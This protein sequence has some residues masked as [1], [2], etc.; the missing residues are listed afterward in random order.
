MCLTAT[1]SKLTRFK[2]KE[3]MQLRQP[4]VFNESPDRPNIR[5]CVKRVAEGPDA[6]AW[7]TNGLIKERAEFPRTI[8]YCRRIKECTEIYL[9]MEQTVGRNSSTLQ[10]RLYDMIHSKT[11][12]HTK[13]HILDSFVTED[14]LLRVLI[15]TK[16]TG[17]GMDMNITNVVHYGCP[18]SIDDYVQ[19]IGRAGRQG[20]QS[21]AI[22]TFSGRQIGRCDASITKI[23]KNCVQPE[24]ICHREIVLNEF[25]GVITENKINPLHLCC[26]VCSKKCECNDCDNALSLYEQYGIDI[27]NV[28]DCCPVSIRYVSDYDLNELKIEMFLLKGTLD[29]DYI[30]TLPVYMKPEI[31]HGLSHSVIKN[32]LDNVCYISSA[33]EL[34][35]LC[36][37]SN[38]RTADAILTIFHKIF[39]DI[40]ADIL[41][42]TTTDT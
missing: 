23:L 11:P 21:H 33:E 30:S 17:M 6:I 40:D 29:L 7:I 39:N 34:I 5:L 16:V 18:S 38:E 35:G 25:G 8:I 31:M 19:Q 36:K 15:S 3:L 26:D 37:V 9:H 22:M 4:M 27:E 20:Q 13:N 10:D 42:E 28:E 32:I 1:A 14:T 41:S 2:V 24:S 12:T